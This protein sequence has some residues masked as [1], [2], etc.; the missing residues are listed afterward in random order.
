MADPVQVISPEGDKG[1]VAAEDL[2]DAL[3]Q[4][5]QLD[6]AG[7]DFGQQAG[8]FGEGVGRGLIPGF[9]SLEAGIAPEAGSIAAQNERRK[10]PVAGKLGEFVGGAAQ[11]AG[12]AALTGGLGEVLSAGADAA[13]DVAKG[14]SAADAAAAAGASPEAISGAAN[15]AAS[16]AP[17]TVEGAENLS[18]AK[19]GLLPYAQQAVAGAANNA[20]NYINEADLGDHD[21]NG[22]ALVHELGIG[23]IT[24]ALSEGGIS[25]FKN[26]IAPPAIKAATKAVDGIQEGMWGLY[27]KGVETLNPEVKGLLDPAREAIEAGA[28]KV[29]NSAAEDL[30]GKINQSLSSTD[31]LTDTHFNEYQPKEATELLKDTPKAQVLGAEPG[32]PNGFPGLLKTHAGIEQALGVIQQKAAG[33]VG[34][35]DK[36]A[37]NNLG[38]IMDQWASDLRDPAASAVDLQ[39]ATLRAR[40]AVDASG[41]WSNGIDNTLAA[42]IRKGVRQPLMD[43]L[44]NPELWGQEM[45]GRNRAINEAFTG[46]LNTRKQALSDL[47]KGALNDVGQKEFSVDAAKLRNSLNGDPLSNK[48]KLQHLDDL[49]A[50]NKTFVKE[51]GTSAA[52]AGAEVPGGDDLHALLESAV[53][54]K[55]ALGQAGAI[56]EVQKALAGSQRWGFGAL[57]VGPAAFGAAHVLGASGPV[58]VGLGAIGAAVRA[59][60]KAMQM[61]AKVSGTAAAARDL[62]GA[63]VRKIF[64]TAPARAAIS[65]T[66]ANAIR[67]RSIQNANGYASGSD[68]Q[69]QSKHIQELASDPARLQDTMGENLGRL[70]DVA[71]N[72]ALAAMGSTVR[73]INILNQAMPKNPN[74]SP[75][76]AEDK[77][78]GPNGTE[79]SAW[80]DLHGALLNPP[81]FLTQVANG[82]ASPVVW[83]ALQQAFPSWTQEVQKST[84]DHILDHPKIQ[85]TTGQKLSASMIL[86]APVSPTVA[87]DQVAFQQA[88]FAPAAPPQGPAGGQPP[89][90]TQTGLAKLD[91]GS[92]SMA[93]H[94]RSK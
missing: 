58:A 18:R 83:T 53:A 35:T 93:G 86:G 3:R 16:V 64:S 74:P 89:K 29:N 65:G 73:A 45:A 46:L 25:I 7:A 5:F 56:N 84:L 88:V 91:L 23:A 63:S 94:Q 68:F 36:T 80:N 61:Y 39:Q 24:G 2:Q 47:G 51:V 57:G 49:L 78:W 1:T 50:A 90:S 43:A 10:I 54:Q 76:P 38:N 70:A 20:T 52:N 41:L 26:T 66:V 62:I 8:A 37:I 13:A 31:D 55:R 6:N 71:P 75:F 28:G 11:L 87:P 42:D 22:Q 9:P 79:E 77:L 72:T 12:V 92:R 19:S 40:R 15:E 4:G 81:S 82:T 48:A 69:K 17:R 33:A 44:N 27:K 59:P 30:A 85:L 14:A 32:V 21:F 60:V 34:Y 67:G